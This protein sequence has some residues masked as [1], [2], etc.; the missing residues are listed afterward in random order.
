M[1]ARLSTGG[2]GEMRY[3]LVGTIS[4]VGTG[5]MGRENLRRKYCLHVTIV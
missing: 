4:T 2:G 5:V 3:V 1:Q